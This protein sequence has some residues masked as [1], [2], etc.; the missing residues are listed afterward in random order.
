[1]NKQNNFVKVKD[2]EIGKVYGGWRNWHLY[3]GRTVTGGFMWLYIGGPESYVGNPLKEVMY[4]IKYSD[5]LCDGGALQVTKQNK[6]IEPTKGKLWETRFN[7]YSLP[8]EY[9]QVLI[10]KGLKPF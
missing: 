4:S 2:L 5:R 8:N 1:M 9:K 3:L 7:I 6:R 10:N